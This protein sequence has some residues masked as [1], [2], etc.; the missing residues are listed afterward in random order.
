MRGIGINVCR[1]IDLEPGDIVV[2]PD[3]LITDAHDLVVLAGSQL[4]YRIVAGARSGV[5][6]C[7]RDDPHDRRLGFGG[8][9]GTLGSLGRSHADPHAV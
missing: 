5:A 1:G 7:L 9:A 4:T 2:D 6:L 8:L 3:D